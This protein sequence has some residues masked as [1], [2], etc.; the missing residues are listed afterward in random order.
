MSRIRGGVN[1]TQIRLSATP[2]SAILDRIDILVAL[3]KGALG[4]LAH[5]ITPETIILAEKNEIDTERGTSEHGLVDVPFTRMAK[6]SGGAVF[7]N[8]VAAGVLAGLLGI[9]PDL[10]SENV[11]QLFS[12]KTSDIVEHNLHAAKAGH[13]FGLELAKSLRPGPEMVAGSNLESQIL[14]NGAQ[15]VGLGAIAGG[16][17]FISSYPMSPS[18]GVLTFLAKNAADL[19][20]IAEQAEDEIAAIN[21]ALGAWY[22]GARAMVTTSGGG[23]ALMAE[24]MSLAGMIE[25]PLVVHLAQRPGPAT[26]LPTRTE[27]G[28]LELA[29]YAGHG[30]FPRA[31]YAPG[32]LEE[33]FYLTQKAFNLADTYQIPVIVLTDQYL[34]DSYYNI[35]PFDLS[36]VRCE[37]HVVETESSYARYRLTPDGV[38]PRGVPGFGKGHVAVDSDEHDEHGHITEDLDLRVK[39]VQKRMKKLVAVTDEVIRPT[40]FGP[41]DYRNL[42]IS[43]GST[44]SAIAEALTRLLRDDTS[45]LHY[46]QVYPV[47]PQT[48]ELLGRAE[49][50]ILIEG[51]ATGQFGKLLK[52]TTGIAIEDRILKYNG[53]SLSVEEVATRLDELLS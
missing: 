31:I 18:T 10:L 34:M 16:C 11:G 19:G 6:E 2:V 15:A 47:H 12:S 35:P 49:K 8:T 51:N 30:D 37:S 33:A 38:S 25:S 50:V 22:A 26:G 3:D 45:W 29:L 42:V 46:S 39:M 20:I 48:A 17:N 53:L 7:S 5:R 27:Q 44:R 52:L 21:M 1:S 14:L 4:H 24:G 28:D 41:D 32:T 43:W 36:D 40:L 9:Q 23:F 13:S